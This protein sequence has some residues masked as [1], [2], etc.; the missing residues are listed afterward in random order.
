MT[1][2][3]TIFIFTLVCSYCLI[4][5]TWIK[6]HDAI[7]IFVRIRPLLQ[8]HALPCLA[9]MFA[10]PFF[11]DGNLFL[12]VNLKFCI[13]HYLYCTNWCIVRHIMSGTSITYITIKFTHPIT[14]FDKFNSI[15]HST[16][17]SISAPHQGQ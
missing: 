17:E 1:A 8:K 7:T 6:A 4:K 9:W 13:C 14:L 3:V 16:S 2:F 5:Q 10:R 12:G 11:D 15:H